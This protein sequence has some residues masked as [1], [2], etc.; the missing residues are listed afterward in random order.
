[1]TGEELDQARAEEAWRRCT[2]PQLLP[3]RDAVIEAA[4]LGREGWMPPDPLE[5]GMIELAA[6]AI[7]VSDYGGAGSYCAEHVEEYWLWLGDHQRLVF[8][9]RARAALEAMREPSWPMRRVLMAQIANNDD[10]LD[11]WRDAI[12]AALEG[13]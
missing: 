10:A 7:M 11:I 8:R 2:D 12:D 1:M 9:R 13:K 6:R 4:R 5:A 3:T